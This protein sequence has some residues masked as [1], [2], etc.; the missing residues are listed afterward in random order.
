MEY[1][2]RGGVPGSNPWRPGKIPEPGGGGVGF[3]T[4]SKVIK[5]SPNGNVTSSKPSGNPWK[6]G[7]RADAAKKKHKRQFDQELGRMDAEKKARDKGILP[8]DMYTKM[9]TGGRF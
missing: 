3:G 8:S 4:G 6:P 1:R 9:K 7:P 5:S 2:P